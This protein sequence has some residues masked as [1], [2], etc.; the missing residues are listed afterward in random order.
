MRLLLQPPRATRGIATCYLN[1]FSIES[2]NTMLL[3]ADLVSRKRRPGCACAFHT[4]SPPPTTT[5]LK[6]LNWTITRADSSNTTD[7]AS[8]RHPPHQKETHTSPHHSR[9]LCFS[10][11]HT[12][13]NKRN[14]SLP[15]QRNNENLLNRRSC[16]VRVVSSAR[17]HPRLRAG[18]GRTMRM[19]QRR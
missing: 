6:P 11:S 4:V 10:F 8:A 2:L 9:K 3:R 18:Y 12:F 19:P 15:L 17:A 7:P 16:R 1:D 5:P 14:H 13:T